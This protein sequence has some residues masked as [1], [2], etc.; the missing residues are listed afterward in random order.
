LCG[1]LL[2]DCTVVA[3]DDLCEVASHFLVVRFF[4]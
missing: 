1:P 3:S 2:F 4:L